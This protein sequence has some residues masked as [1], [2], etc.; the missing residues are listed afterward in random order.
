VDYLFPVEIAGPITMPPLSTRADFTL[1][2][3]ELSAEDIDSLAAA[4]RRD[5]G[6][7]A[8]RVLI[9]ERMPRS[10]RDYAAVLVGSDVAARDRLH[11]SDL[12]D[13]VFPVLF[14]ANKLIRFA[15][16]TGAIPIV[17]QDWAAELLI[18]KAA[19]NSARIGGGL[20]TMRGGV[21]AAAFA[22]GL[23]LDFVG[24]EQLSRTP[25]DRLVDFKRKHRSLLERHQLHLIKVAQAFAS[26]PDDSHF[27]DRLAE[28][29]LEAHRDRV[30]LEAH[31]RDAW[32]VSGL[33]LLKK[34]VTAA[35]A[36]L[37]SGLAVLRGHTLQDVLTAAL[38]AAAA[39]GGVVVAAVVDA[40]AKAHASIA[41][42]M[43]YL[44]RARDLIR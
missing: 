43:T 4:A 17:G 37:F 15:A 13:P 23:A 34:A 6:D 29:R 9:E 19:A 40:H 36:G 26:L 32:A 12:A 3:P 30:D 25:I 39:A 16:T 27:D 22:A 33:E 31:A 10:E 18:G 14:L 21:H 41:S 2:R 11:A 28:L 8:T 38:P 5:A 1:R 42:S 7:D 24:D 20:L 44:F 35:S